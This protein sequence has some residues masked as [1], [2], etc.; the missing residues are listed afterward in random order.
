MYIPITYYKQNKTFK[1]THNVIG[2]LSTADLENSTFSS[3]SNDANF[4]FP[5]SPSLSKGFLSTE[6]L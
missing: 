2:M 6:L 1:K 4:N 3:N 5:F